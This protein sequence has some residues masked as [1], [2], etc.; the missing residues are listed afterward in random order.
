MI[1]RTW[2]I[3]DRLA[4]GSKPPRGAAV[5]R[6]GFSDLVLCAWEEQPP[7]EAFSGIAVHRV[8]LDDSGLPPSSVDFRNAE[9][10]AAHV[11]NLVR[12]GRSVLVTCQLGMNRSGLVSALALRRLTGKDGRWVRSYMRAKR[13]RHGRRPLSNEWFAAYVEGKGEPRRAPH[14]QHW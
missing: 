3:R 5:A 12:R 4:I 7:D 13:E 9:A 10:M 8:L 6:A 11:A 14:S 2:L 1:D